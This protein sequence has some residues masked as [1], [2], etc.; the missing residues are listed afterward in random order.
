MT[1]ALPDDRLAKRNVTVLV[2]AQAI[3]GGQMPMMFVVG[4]L[5]GGMLTGNPCFATLPIS[6][7]VFGSMTTAP[8]LSPLMQ[9]IWPQNRVFYWSDCR[10]LGRCGLGLWALCRILCHLPSGILYFGHLYV[11]AGVLPLC[12]NRHCLGQFPP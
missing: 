8:W 1:Q 2:A 12:R 6:L 11:R 10:C 7:I 3:L 9:K 4:G 5:A